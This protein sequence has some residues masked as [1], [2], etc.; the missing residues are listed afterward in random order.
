MAR[1]ATEIGREMMVSSVNVFTKI[2][3]A[4]PKMREYF[5]QRRNLVFRGMLPVIDDYV[6][7]RHLLLETPPKEPVGLITDKDTDTFF[8]VSLAGLLNIH[9]INFAAWTKIFLP[10]F[11]AAPAVDANL[12]DINFAS[13]KFP[14]VMVVNIQIMFPFPNP[15][16]CLVVIKVGPQ[17]I[18]ACVQSGCV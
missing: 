7:C 17:G 18:L 10:H 8:L 2:Y 14:K 1:Q 13:H 12:Q 6:E 16:P 4:G 5:L 15:S 3:A 11:E 9:P